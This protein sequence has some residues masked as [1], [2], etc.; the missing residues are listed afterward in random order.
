MVSCESRCDVIHWLNEK[1]KSD[2]SSCFL[3]AATGYFDWKEP[4]IGRNLVYMGL[5]GVAGFIILLCIEYR[6][7]NGIIYGLNKSFNK[8][9]PSEPEESTIDDD[10]SGEK[11]R[12]DA[13]NPLDLETHNLVLRRLTK[14]YGSFLAVDQLSIGIKQ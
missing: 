12:V 6:L 8:P 9:P 7:F 3:S 1:L 13:M 2:Q 4:G 5:I 11:R 10:V 14:Y